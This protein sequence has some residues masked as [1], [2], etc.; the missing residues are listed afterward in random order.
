MLVCCLHRFFQLNS[1]CILAILPIFAKVSMDYFKVELFT[2]FNIFWTFSANDT[3]FNTICKTDDLQYR[4]S[5][6]FIK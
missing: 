6:I 5:C 3:V 4:H 1:F 2:V